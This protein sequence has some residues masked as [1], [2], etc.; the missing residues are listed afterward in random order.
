MGGEGRQDR[1]VRQDA[2]KGTTY[3]VR[4]G[5]AQHGRTLNA[6]RQNMAQQA[7]QGRYVCMA[8]YGTRQARQ[9]CLAVRQE[10]KLVVKTDR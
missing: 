9:D 3:A 10:S 5:Q 8:G 4:A 6:V 2:G 1:W 7:S